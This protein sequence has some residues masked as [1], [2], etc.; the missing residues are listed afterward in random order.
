MHLDLGHAYN[1]PPYSNYFNISSY[2]AAW[3]RRINGCHLHQV[4][5]LPEGRKN[6]Q[7]LTGWF[8]RPI[9][10]S[11]LAL[12]WRRGQIAHIPLILEI[13]N[14]EGPASLL[15]LRHSAESGKKQL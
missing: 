4:A 5:M 10:L 14:G 12:A 8:E 9:A 6:H 11:S 1:N 3:G 13:R 7:A 15:A 2:L